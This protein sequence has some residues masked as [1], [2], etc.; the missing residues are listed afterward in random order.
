MSSADPVTV[1]LVVCAAPLA[2]R[3]HELAAALVAAGFRVDVAPTPEASRNWVDGEALERAVCGVSAAEFRSA[4]SA[5]RGG[6]PDAVVAA[7]LTFNSLNKWALGISD[8]RA[9]G[10]LNESL[11]RG[12][13]IVAAP[14]VNAGLWGHPALSAHLD[15]LRRAGVQFV[16]VHDG[17][18]GAEP[19]QSGTGGALAMMFDTSWVT[20]R[21]ANLLP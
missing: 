21:L 12:I 5:R 1:A 3:A 15:T 17:Q 11:G 8:N 2:E 19:V 6:K 16:D 7:P 18:P 10:T 9:M 13:P 4:E 20:T 14:M